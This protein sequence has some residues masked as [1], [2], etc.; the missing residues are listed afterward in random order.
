M[1]VAA[2]KVRTTA[3]G[4]VEPATGMVIWY[5]PQDTLSLLQGHVSQDTRVKR[6]TCQKI[7]VV[8]DTRGPHHLY[9]HPAPPAAALVAAMVTLPCKR[10]EY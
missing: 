9:G 5:S 8:R 10:I 3:M 1:V 7:H 2:S 6:Y 4:A